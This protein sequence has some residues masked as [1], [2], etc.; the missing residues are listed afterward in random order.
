M[1]SVLERERER[2]NMQLHFYTKGEKEGN[3]NSFTINEEVATSYQVK[4]LL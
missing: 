2:K 1:K 3:T 4:S